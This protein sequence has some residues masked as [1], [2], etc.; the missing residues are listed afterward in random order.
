MGDEEKVRSAHPLLGEVF[1]VRYLHEEPDLRLVAVSR[2]GEIVPV[3]HEL[4]VKVRH[5]EGRAKFSGDPNDFSTAAEAREAFDVWKSWTRRLQGF[6]DG[7]VETRKAALV[8]W[9]CPSKEGTAHIGFS[10]CHSDDTFSKKEAVLHAVTNGIGLE[11]DYKAA[12]ES[13]RN[14]PKLHIFVL[15]KIVVDA[16]PDFLKGD[17]DRLRGLDLPAWIQDVLR[18]ES[19]GDIDMDFVRATMYERG[20]NTLFLPEYPECLFHSNQPVKPKLFWRVR[21]VD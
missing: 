10:V 19:E 16:L 8:A 14:G 6:V 15:P 5:L 9:K 17:M 18:V 3:E 4:E 12:R 11:Y 13:K 2:C 20:V 7:P 1:V 21:S